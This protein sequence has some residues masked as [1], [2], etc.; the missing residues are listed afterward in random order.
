M[1]ISSPLRQIKVLFSNHAPF[2]KAFCSRKIY[3][4]INRVEFPPRY[5]NSRFAKIN[6]DSFARSFNNTNNLNIFAQK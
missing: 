2:A 4:F 6:N 5:I 3:L 1:P